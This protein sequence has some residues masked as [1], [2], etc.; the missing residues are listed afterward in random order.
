M[1]AGLTP[2]DI[3]MKVSI[4]NLTQHQL[5]QILEE[6]IELNPELAPLITTVKN[7]EGTAKDIILGI[8]SGFNLDDILYFAETMPSK[9][10]SEYM[11]E[12][13][14]EQRHLECQN[15]QEALGIKLNWIP[16]PATR[17]KIENAL[18]TSPETPSLG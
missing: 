15:W 3:A 4:D 7:N 9:H 14:I 17:Q 16:S 13:L 5:K 11:R 2:K 12:T 18:S 10:E 1:P 8:T 6:L